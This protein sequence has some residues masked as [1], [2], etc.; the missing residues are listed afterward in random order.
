MTGE[1]AFR[2]ENPLG[3]G[4]AVHVVGRGLGPYQ[5]HVVS[6]PGALDGGVGTGDDDTAGQARRGTEPLGDRGDVLR[7]ALPHGRRIHEMVGD[8]LHGLGACERK[9]LVAG[10]VDCDLERR[11]RRALAGAGLQHPELAPL[12]GELDVAHVPVVPLE[13]ICVVAQLGGDGRHAFVQS[14]DRLRRGRA[15]HHV[16]ALGLEHDVAVE[17]FLTGRR[18]PGEDDTCA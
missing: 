14:R 6:G 8:A 2:G 4:H 11:L 3:A 17:A 15:R 10:H 16:L 13:P 9:V 18:V 7:R 12:D 1:A 5:D